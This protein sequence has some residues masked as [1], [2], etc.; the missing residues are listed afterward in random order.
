MVKENDFEGWNITPEDLGN[1]EKDFDLFLGTLPVDPKRAIKK[2]FKGVGMA[3][4]DRSSV[5][6]KIVGFELANG[7]SPR[8]PTEQ[9]DL[10]AKDGHVFRILLDGSEVHILMG[11]FEWNRVIEVQNILRELYERTIDAEGYKYLRGMAALL[12]PRPE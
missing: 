3:A 5:A 12:M 11:G 7:L 9:E 6:S 10:K 1:L 8:D 2:A 4:T